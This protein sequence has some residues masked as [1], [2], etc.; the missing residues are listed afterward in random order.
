MP[1]DDLAL[2]ALVA[3]AAVVGSLHTLAGPD[4]YVPFVAMAKAGRFKVGRLSAIVLACG[5]GHCLSSLVLAFG[6]VWLGREATSMDG[7]Q[8]WRKDLA[9][10][11]LIAF[12]GWLIAR[13][14]KRRS[15]P[16]SLEG[17]PSAPSRPKLAGALFIVLVLGP[18][19]WLIPNCVLA[20]ATHGERA[21]WPIA[22]VFTAATMATMLAAVLVLAFGVGR[23]RAQWME[24]NATWVAGASCA[25]S[26][27]A[28][29]AGL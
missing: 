24:R 17:A 20:A 25:L 18:C 28:V 2:S 22:I 14:L 5:L 26:G 10:W 7:V 11:I 13:G 19:E 27:L 6:A 12:G 23:I 1:V 21:V 3:Q 9:A 29:L 15:G 8:E 16:E 4:H